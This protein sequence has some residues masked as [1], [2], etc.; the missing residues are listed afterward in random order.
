MKTVQADMYDVEEILVEYDLMKEHCSD[1]KVPV[2]L[3]S[4]DIV[5]CPEVIPETPVIDDCIRV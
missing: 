5:G 1:S 4:G 3:I 2:G